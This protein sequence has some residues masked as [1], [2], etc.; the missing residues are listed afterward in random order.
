M[1]G[2]GVASSSGGAG[3]AGFGSSRQLPVNG[4]AGLEPS[5][6]DRVRKGT[7]VSPDHEERR[8]IGLLEECRADRISCA[9]ELSNPRQ[10]LL[11]AAYARVS[12]ALASIRSRCNKMT[13]AIGA[14]GKQMRDQRK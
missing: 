6:A 1:G 3:I 10:R 4:G 12:H 7:E 8:L 9:L 13:I 14:H 2:N 5:R 11:H